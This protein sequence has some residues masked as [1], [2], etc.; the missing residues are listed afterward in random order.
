MPI[1]FV[2]RKLGKSKLTKAEFKGFISYVTKSM[3]GSLTSFLGKAHK[4]IGSRFRT[5]H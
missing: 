2:N 3:F 1:T 4:M 5:I